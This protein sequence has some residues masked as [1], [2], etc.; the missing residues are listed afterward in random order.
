VGFHPVGDGLMRLYFRDAGGIRTQDER[1][2]PFFH[3]AESGLIRRFGRKH[4][5]KE[6]SGTGYYRFVCVFEDWASMWEAVR[7]AMEE[8]ARSGFSR[9]TSYAE[10]E[11][12]YLVPDPSTQF[13]MQSGYTLFKGLTFDDLNRLQLDI[14][15]Y[16][17]DPHRFSNAK[18]PA[19]RIILI[20]LSDAR[21]W[22]HI[23][24]GRRKSEQAM[25]TEL[26]NIILERNPDILEGH[27]ILGFD[28]PYILTRCAL[29][30]INF[31]IGRDGSIPVLTT[32][33]YRGEGEDTPHID[34][35]GRH[36]ID[37][38]LLVQNYDATKR[39][40]ESYGLKYAARFFGFASETRTY[41]E[42][43]RIAWYWDNDPQALLPYALDDVRETGMLSAHLSGSAIFLARMVPSSLATIIRGGAASKIE[44]LLLRAYLHARHS[45]SRP[46]EGVQ[47]TGGYT[48]LFLTGLVGPVVHADVE[49]LYPAIMLSHRIQPAGDH[50]GVFLQLLEELTA[51]RIDAKRAMQAAK[52]ERERSRLDAV[53]SAFKI[54]INSFYGYLGYSR[55]LFNDFPSADRVTSTGQ[56]ILRSMIHEI[57]HDGGTVVEVDT[58]GV[59]FIA[60]EGIQG[61]EGARSY[62][63]SLSS[64]MPR[65]ITVAFSGM[66]ARMLSYRRKNY[67]LLEVGGRVTIKGSSLVSRSMEGFGRRFVRD[68]VGH[69]LR[70]EIAALHDLYV[71]TYNRIA[72]R[73][74][75]VRE[76]A[77]VEVLRDPL[78]VYLEEVQGGKRNKSAAYEVAITSGKEPRAGTRIAYY[79]T[80]SDAGVRVSD[81]SRS[82]DEWN[83][84]FPDEN[85]AFY[86][87][88]LDEFAAKFRD[89]F[90]PQHFRE[91]FSAE[92]LFPFDPSSIELVVT[93]VTSEPPTATDQEQSSVNTDQT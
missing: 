14:E 57:Q 46:G 87:Q 52:E 42:G 88:R 20:A 21:G 47:T 75:D 1:F 59:L 56:Q 24:D 9:P 33:G 13:L 37:T 32:R 48:D 67:A 26:A 53:Q 8:S 69:L 31:P 23:I 64:R 4:W 73:T 81:H 35:A 93:K 90:S 85:T 50:L 3:L 41:I 92:N 60:P 84:N 29:H 65:G 36:I 77:R 11:Q 91:I 43:D 17:S 45:L 83:P 58:D 72:A 54:L 68:A 62:V 79:V 74:L 44:A 15:T 30:G 25:L 82:V 28:L 34:I 40:M 71:D 16:S 78:P 51:M 76:L 38:L 6:L 39:S 49:S 27:N 18:I 5:M 86:L 10:L 66:Y 12:M 22:E 89:F 19:D 2:Y 61:E 7:I 80:G 70:G 63:G 55:A